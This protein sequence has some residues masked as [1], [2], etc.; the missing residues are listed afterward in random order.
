MA[1][2][3]GPMMTPAKVAATRGKSGSPTNVSL[4][5]SAT[6]SQRTRPNWGIGPTV[7]SCASQ[8]HMRDAMRPTSATAISQAR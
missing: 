1:I 4:A 2:R 5:A 8:D 3:A 6:P 7:V